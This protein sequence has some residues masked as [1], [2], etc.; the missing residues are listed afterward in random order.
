MTTIFIHG[1]GAGKET[2]HDVTPLVPDSV[3]LDLPGWGDEPWE[4]PAT[5]PKLADW[6]ASKIDALGT[7]PAVVFGHS[8][9]GMLALETALTHPDRVRAFVACATSPAF[10]GRD[11][12]FKEQFLAGRL[13]PLDEGMT[14]PELA[15]RSAESMGGPHVSDEAKARFADSMGRLPEKV[16]R[17]V[18]RCL[19]TFNRREDLGRVEQPVLCLAGS[20][21]ETAPAKTMAKMAEKLPKG[22]YAEIAGG[23]LLPVERPR[24]TA[25]AVNAFVSKLG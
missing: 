4:K 24:E 14:M 23:H 2:F 13:K 9:G 18:V 25:E 6:L 5:F 8:F 15:R 16:Y 3:A 1:I 20:E 11:E 21:D 10:G 22:E 7:G 19:V 12:S 17:D